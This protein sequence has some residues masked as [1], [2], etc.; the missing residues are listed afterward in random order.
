MSQENGLRVGARLH[1]VNHILQGVMPVILETCR[2]GTDVYQ[3]V[4]FH[5]HQGRHN[6]VM[7]AFSVVMPVCNLGIEHIQLCAHCSQV[8]NV[9]HSLCRTVDAQPPTVECLLCRGKNGKFV[10]SCHYTAHTFQVDASSVRAGWC[11]DGQHLPHLRRYV[12]VGDG[13][14]KA[15]QCPHV[16]Q[17]FLPLHRLCVVA[18]P[19]HG[20]YGHPIFG[21]NMMLSAQKIHLREQVAV[22]LAAVFQCLVANQHKG[23]VCQPVQRSRF[24]LAVHGR[25]FKY[26]R[27]DVLAV[28]DA[29]VHPVG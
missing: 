27:I 8:A 19:S 12:T 22:G 1:A 11:R 16:V 14:H 20:L 21:G 28:H 29:I 24:H 3:I 9:L 7:G 5:H 26:A 15:A 25:Q 4:G 10:Y 23:F 6:G 2:N 18:V 17:E 13:R